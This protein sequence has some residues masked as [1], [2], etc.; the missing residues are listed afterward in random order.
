MLLKAS[1]MRGFLLSGLYVYFVSRD[2]GVVFKRLWHLPMRKSV[3]CQF[4][5]FS[6]PLSLAVT[7]F[8]ILLAFSPSY[9]E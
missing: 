7:L 2:A 9:Y 1:L 6:P 3:F 8:L 5:I 4:Q